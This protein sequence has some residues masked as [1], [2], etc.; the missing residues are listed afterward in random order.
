MAG[1]L[2]TGLSALIGSRSALDTVGHNIANVNTPGYSRQRVNF[3]PH[4]AQSTP[5]GFIGSGVT[6]SSVE[7]FFNQ[8]IYEN[9][10]DS[11]SLQSNLATLTN[12][13]ERVNNLLADP[14]IGLAP[15]LQGFFDSLQD[16]ANDP[17]SIELRQ[18]FLGQAEGLAERLALLE[19]EIQSIGNEVR[20]GVESSVDE[21]N[22]LSS[23]IADLNA[24]I[25]VSQQ[26]GR[27]APND[28][29]DRRDLRI[30]ELSEL[31]GIE[32]VEDTDGAINVIALPGNSLV[33]GPQANSLSLRA[34]PLNPSQYIVQITALNSGTP[35][36]V[37]VSGGRLSALLDTQTDLLDGIS[38]DLGQTA[39]AIAVAINEQTAQGIDL[40][41]NAGVDL[42]S[43]DI[44]PDISSVS[45]AGSASFT[46]S[47]DDLAALTGDEYRISFD[48]ANFAIR[49]SS[50]DSLVT[51]TG[52]GSVGDPL[53]F[54]GLSVVLSGTANAG[55]QFEIRPTRGVAG[56]MRVSLT[57]PAGLALASPVSTSSSLNNLGDASIGDER[58]ID[59]SDPN[60]L[61]GASIVFLTPTTYSVDGAGSFAYT[62][63]QPIS[64]NGVEFTISGTPAAG[65]SFALSANTNANGD[66]RNALLMV[67]L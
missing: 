53:V 15:S 44:S 41:G 61:S 11:T 64:L 8:L 52:T 47:I 46:T 4:P 1:F 13:S 42:F 31:I 7:R 3:V 22:S 43:I 24:K 59:A 33:T 29:L 34:D 57:D 40:N 2:T 23:E 12:Y 16:A 38:R 49:R 54:D 26:G 37:P 10:N 25:V 5:V 60:L 67:E 17:S 48:G 6:A 58:V 35:V 9:I 18:V 20:L 30:A 32:T 63:G 51:P 56:N 62:S 45:N 21:I 19:N 50:D 55:D 36:D 28:L 66:N 27:V 39:L 14:S 65:D